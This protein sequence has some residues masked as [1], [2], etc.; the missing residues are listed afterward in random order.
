ME[1]IQCPNCLS[2][3]PEDSQYCSKCGSSLEANEETIPYAPSQ[4]QL[5]KE[6]IHYSPGQS[7]GKR[8]IIIEEIGRGGMGNVYKAEDKELGITV[9]LK[10]IKSK[11]SRN[12]HFIERFKKETL[13]ARSI[14]HENVIRIHD[15]GDLEG[16]KY[17][18][19]DYIKGQS[20]RD[21]VYSSGKLTV[22]TALK[23]TDDICK[24]LKAAHKKG[25]IHRDLKP[26]NISFKA[27]NRRPG[28]IGGHLQNGNGTG[29]LL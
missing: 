9:A 13:L 14:S 12:K 24:A 21:L 4:E 26:Q 6:R 19:M 22:E 18:S 27:L 11:Y 23:I 2:L 7:F 15:I 17:I 5:T 10:V 29:Q 28:K 8:Y 1:N 16:I 25:I 3:N 20:L